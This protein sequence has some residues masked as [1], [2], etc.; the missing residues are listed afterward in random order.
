MPDT[1]KSGGIEQP[2]LEGAGDIG[3]RSAV[4]ELGERECAATY[5]ATARY[6]SEVDDRTTGKQRGVR[7]RW[8]SRGLEAA[9]LEYYARK[10]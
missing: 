6:S 2:S 9:D 1:W 3:L 7:G 4:V 5:C 8:S 10:G